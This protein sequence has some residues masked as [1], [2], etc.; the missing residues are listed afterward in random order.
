MKRIFILFTLTLLVGCS[1]S[2]DDDVETLI[3]TNYLEP[4][5]EYEAPKSKILNLYGDDFKTE[6][7][8]FSLGY[9]M[10]YEA[11]HNGIVNYYFSL[12]N[13]KT[14]WESEATF[15]KGKENVDF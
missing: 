12:D 11:R 8:N 3:L 5:F 6:N 1:S 13:S 15:H 2:S 14:L 9:K 10:I 4:F 7:N